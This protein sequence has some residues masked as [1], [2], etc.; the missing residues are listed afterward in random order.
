M[1]FRSDL[2]QLQRIAAQHATRARFLEDLALD[3]PQ[4]TSAEAGPPTLDEDWL[5]LS[6]IH[7]AKGQ[8]WKAVYILNAVDGCIPSDLA[9]GTVEEIEEER[10]LLYVA[11]TRARDELVVMQPMRFYVRGAMSDKHVYAP[12]TRFIADEDLPAYEVLSPAPE[13]AGPDVAETAVRI[14]LKSA[15]RSMW[16]R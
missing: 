8:E 15:M 11:M 2:D 16:R 3:P 10:R 12:R 7:S 14:D 9:T 6:T 5:V 1:L 13:T 4:A